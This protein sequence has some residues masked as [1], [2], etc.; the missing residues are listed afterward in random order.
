MTVPLSQKPAYVVFDYVEAMV[1]ARTGEV[2]RPAFW[3]ATALV[4]DRDMA[5]AW[6]GP[7]GQVLETSYTHG[8]KIKDAQVRYTDA[9]LANFFA[10]QLMAAE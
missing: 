1:N 10:E 4:N 8:S 5:E 9:D 2:F 3:K 7:Y 6:A